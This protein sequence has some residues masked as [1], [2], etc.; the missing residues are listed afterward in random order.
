MAA[1]DIDIDRMGRY[2]WADDR[3]EG[4]YTDPVRY[5]GSERLEI[6]GDLLPETGTIRDRITAGDIGHQPLLPGVLSK[7]DR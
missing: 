7:P 5:T 6:A 3:D 1:G 2:A 4:H